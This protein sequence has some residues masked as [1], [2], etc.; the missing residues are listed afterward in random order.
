MSCVVIFMGRYTFRGGNGTN[1]PHE[2][3]TVAPPGTTCLAGEAGTVGV[4]GSARCGHTC[5]VPR[6]RSE[7]RP[8]PR[9]QLG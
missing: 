7:S 3:G 9:A 2:L 4:A 6:L 1:V 5:T 8:S